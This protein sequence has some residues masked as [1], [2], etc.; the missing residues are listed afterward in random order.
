MPQSSPY[1][2]DSHGTARFGCRL[3]GAGAGLRTI[4]AALGHDSIPSSIGYQP[5]ELDTARA[6]QLAATNALAKVR[7]HG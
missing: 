2:A 4:M 5:P 1:P 3:D 7:Q 6:A